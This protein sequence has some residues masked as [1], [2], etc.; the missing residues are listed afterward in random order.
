[1]S[2]TFSPSAKYFGK[3][4]KT[5]LGT[6]TNY[7]SSKVTTVKKKKNELRKKFKLS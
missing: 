7:L 6:A 1:M 5:Q 3:K 4:T 2:L